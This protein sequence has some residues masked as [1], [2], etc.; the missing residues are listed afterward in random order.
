M[1]NSK[2]QLPLLS[3][4]L[5]VTLKSLKLLNGSASISELEQKA[6]EIGNYSDEQLSVPHTGNESQ[7]EINYKLHW[8]R[9]YLKKYGLINNSV[10]GIWS[11]NNADLDIDTIDTEK[12]VKE[13]RISSS[14]QRKEGKKT[15]KEESAEFEVETYDTEAWKDNLLSI[16][17][18]MT[19][20]GFERLS[21]NFLRECGF[22]SVNVSGKS[23][24][25]GIDGDGI[26]LQNGI[27][28]HRILFQCK[29][30][31]GSISPSQVR[32]FRGAMQGRAEKG[33]FITT[34]SF[35]KEARR[36]ATRDGAPLIDL[37]DGDTLCDKMKELK[38]GL[39]IELVEK[40]TINQEW[41]SRF[42]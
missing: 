30:Y 18:K 11:L 12:I 16:L 6:I 36:E 31:Q 21:Q 19:P 39:S 28:S 3:E 4:L 15:K 24:D 22:T 38:L 17:Y 27:L 29:R 37:I 33:L 23:G 2:V 8:S 35:T 1:Q 40:V 10:R 13:V 7:S 20:S 41:F 32:D 42:S 14:K 25:G 34:G 9:T 5:E 26:L